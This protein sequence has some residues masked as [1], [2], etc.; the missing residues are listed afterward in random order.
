MPNSVRKSDATDL[1]TPARKPATNNNNNSSSSGNSTPTF[2]RQPRKKRRIDKEKDNGQGQQQLQ[3]QL[4][5]CNIE[6]AKEIDR[7]LRQV[8]RANCI[9]SEDMHRV[10][11][12]VV[13]NE[14]VLALVTLKAEDEMAR[15]RHEAAKVEQLQQQQQ[16]QQQPQRGAIIITETPSVGKLTRAKARELNRNPGLNFPP[17][18]EKPFTNEIEA[19]IREDL[20]SDEDDEEYTFTNE[21]FHSDDDP[22]TTASDLDSNPCTPQTPLTANDESPIKF[23]SDGCF[24]LPPDKNTEDPRIATRTRSKL[25]LQQTTIE[26]LQSEFVPPDV[27][28]SD[29]LEYD[30]T[31]NDAEWMQFLNDFA[32]PLNN[33][34]LGD[35][36]DPINDPEY[37]AGEVVPV[38]AE[39]LRD[40]NISKKELTDLVS[41]LFAG[42]LQEGISLDS[43]ELE[44]PQKFLSQVELETERAQLLEVSAMRFNTNLDAVQQ[45]LLPNL[46]Q[47]QQFFANIPT[48]AITAHPDYELT[49]PPTAPTPAPPPPVPLPAPALEPYDTN[50]SWKYL[51][52]SKHFFAEYEQ[53]FEQLRHLKPPPAGPTPSSPVKG[54]TLEQHDLLQQQL[55]IHTQMLTQSFLQTYSHPLLYSFAEQPKQMLLELQHRSTQDASFRCWNLS[56]A[57]ELIQKWERDLNSDEFEE[58]NKTMMQFINKE[59]DLTEGH[60]RQVPR[61]P[62]RIMD[63]MLD[64]QV[65]MYP[66]YLP[67]I[68]FQ[69]RRLQFT[70]YAPAEY[71]LIAMGLEKHLNAIKASGQPLRKGADPVC[72]ACK[73]M[74]KDLLHGKQPR[75]LFVKVKELCDMATYNPVKYYFEHGRAP[76][77]KQILW[78]FE[79]G[80]VRT[81]REQP[82]ILPSAWKYYIEW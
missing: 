69:P 41:E 74:A 82:E 51:S 21:D 54:F 64:S 70:V 72:L 50:F 67:R 43:I 26:D 37:V 16:S 30:M 75:R 31:A 23:S 3:Q 55:R 22:N 57:V 60:A 58:Q 66:Q 20:H 68:A 48:Q 1:K 12:Q 63:L 10:V 49:A 5:E 53:Q 7:R 44:T 71:Q 19:L 6:D 32:K 14:H 79:G 28:Q 17:L 2:R 52:I 36:D 8:A 76:P 27:E 73:R 80:L 4:G 42:L 13:R 24:K 78:G 59:T 65:F 81:P 33:S 25:C 56:T 29:V 18:N 62:P 38:D 61:L 77:I 15:E 9:S 40:V 45:P 34:F 47:E 39:E 35:D 11:R 46:S